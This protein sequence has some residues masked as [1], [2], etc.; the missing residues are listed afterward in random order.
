MLTG[1]SYQTT[2]HYDKTINNQSMKLRL[3]CGK[4]FFFSSLNAFAIVLILFHR[5]F[6]ANTMNE[7]PVYLFSTRVY[8]NRVFVVAVNALWPFGHYLVDTWLLCVY[9]HCCNPF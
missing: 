6:R 4:M 5:D 7:A 2:P 9:V 1:V 8:V 3:T